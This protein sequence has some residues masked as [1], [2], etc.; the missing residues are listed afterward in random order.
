MPNEAKRDPRI[1]PKVGDILHRR[2]TRTITRIGRLRPE[3]AGFIGVEYWTPSAKSPGWM[4]LSKWKRWAKKAEVI[5]C[6][7]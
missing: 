2:W 1:V 7:D 4:I 3:R 5:H 6:A